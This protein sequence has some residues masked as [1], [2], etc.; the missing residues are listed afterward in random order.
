M[1]PIRFCVTLLVSI[2]AAGAAYADFFTKFN[3]AIKAAKNAG[4]PVTIPADA[5]PNAQ[6]APPPPAAPGNASTPGTGGPG[7][8]TVEMMAPADLTAALAAS[9]GYVVIQLSSYDSSC[10]F[11]AQ[12]NPTFDQLA[13]GAAGRAAFWRAMYQPWRSAWPN[14][15]FVK[16]YGIG[17][18]PATLTFKD[19]QLVR[20]ANGNLQLAEMEQRLLQGLR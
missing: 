12:A 11:C 13:S 19:G 3:K 4:L 5:W 6:P 9:R 20:R 17:G 14:D 7:T 18:L 2:C 1:P 10:P 16:T 8:G 15:A